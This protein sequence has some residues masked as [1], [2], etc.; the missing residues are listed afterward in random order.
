MSGRL[1]DNVLLST[2]CPEKRRLGTLVYPQCGRC[3]LVKII[4]GPRNSHNKSPE[5]S[6]TSKRSECKNFPH[7]CPPLYSIHQAPL[8]EL[9][10]R[11]V[12]DRQNR[13]DQQGNCMCRRRPETKSNCRRDVSS[14]GRVPIDW[15][16]R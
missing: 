6:S 11:G 15:T 9:W 14:T 10:S 16:P 3:M 12:T 13:N 7:Q 4:L 2:P 8:C 5:S 1:P